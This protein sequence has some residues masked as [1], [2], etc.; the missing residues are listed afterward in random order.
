V[1]GI[2]CSREAAVWW[3]PWLGVCHAVIFL[4]IVFHLPVGFDRQPLCRA[5]LDNLRTAQAVRVADSTR[6]PSVPV[7][8]QYGMRP[9]RVAGPQSYSGARLLYCVSR[10]IETYGAIEGTVDGLNP[11]TINH[12]AKT[13]SWTP[14]GML[15]TLLTVVKPNSWVKPA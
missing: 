13:I 5:I 3:M 15:S 6:G 12:T 1:F 14:I 4:A 8:H 2:T 11:L 7:P 10:E 9:H